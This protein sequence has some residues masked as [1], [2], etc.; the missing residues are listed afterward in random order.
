MHLAALAELDRS[1]PRLPPDVPYFPDLTTLLANEDVQAVVLCL[2]NHLHAEATVE[3]L[4]AGKHVYVEKPMA[5]D[6]EQA[7]SMLAAHRKTDR[8]GAVGL[9]LRFHPLYTRA[10]ALMPKIGR[11]LTVRTVFSSRRRQLPAWKATRVQGGGVLLDLF[12]H[13]A[14]VLRFILGTEFLDVRAKLRSVS[15]E[16]D[17]AEVWI[18]T[19]NGVQI[20]SF[21]SLSSVEE[22]RLEFFGTEAKLVV[23][24]YERRLTLRSSDR[25]KTLGRRLQRAGMNWLE[26]NR[27]LI[28]ALAPGTEPSFERHLR[29]FFSACRG[30]TAEYATF[31]DGLQSLKLV[32]AAEASARKYGTLIRLDGED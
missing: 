17:T 13:H 16:D 23:D 28:R 21:Y 7:K 5:L 2:P 29:A 8:I 10:E 14:D 18:T 32:L 11:L 22:D 6:L 25:P 19:S 24:R 3:A 15:S 4:E 12:S 9:N 30:E 27:A 26:A 31:D 1:H 20:Q